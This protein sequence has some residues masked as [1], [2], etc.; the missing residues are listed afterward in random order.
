MSWTNRQQDLIPESA[1]E[2]CEGDIAV[3][4]KD[5]GLDYNIFFGEASHIGYTP[6]GRPDPRND[7]YIADENG[8]LSDDQTGSILGE[9]NVW[10][11]N[12]AVSDPRCYNTHADRY[13]EITRNADMSDIY[14]RFE[15]NLKPGCRIL[16]LGCGSGRDSKYFLD[17]GYDVVS[18]HA[19]EAMCR[20]TQELTT[21]VIGDDRVKTLMFL[22]IDESA[23]D[24]G[25]G[26]AILKKVRAEYPDQKL[27]L[28]IEPLDEN[29]PNYDQRCRRKAFY[30]RNGLSCLDY[31]VREAGVT[32][33]MMTYGEYVTR[34]EYEE[35]MRVMYGSLLYKIIKRM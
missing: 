9:W 13:S 29:A 33:E 26:S 35:V 6:S 31:Q 32:Y 2:A 30:E 3:A 4:L 11:E 17:K 7:L 28:N 8:Y 24:G 15:E 23:R 10:E 22:A 20:K 18:L 16:D 14:K 34:D 21:Y 5:S 27:F 12:G 25:Y 19:S 1:W